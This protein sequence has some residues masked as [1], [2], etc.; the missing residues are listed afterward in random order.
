M[1]VAFMPR[2]LSGLEPEHQRLMSSAGFVLPG[3]RH[4]LP[5][6][7]RAG[8]ALKDALVSPGWRS[9][10]ALPA[11]LPLCRHGAVM[12]LALTKT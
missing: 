9:F 5:P 10:V 1:L 12:S 4:E 8:G 6:F 11:L 7:V 3:T 2:G